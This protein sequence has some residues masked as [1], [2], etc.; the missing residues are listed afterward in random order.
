MCVA[1]FFPGHGGTIPYSMPLYEMVTKSF[2]SIHFV[3]NFIV[4]LLIATEAMLLNYII[5]ENE[6]LSKP[7]FLPAL[8][9]IVFMTTDNSLL[10][11]YPLLFANFF[12]LLAIHRLMSSYRKDTA[13]PNSF[14]ASFLLS[15]ATLFYFPCV[16]FLPILFIGFVLFRP[17]NWREWIIS[18]IGI[19]L[20]YIFIFTY[21][22][23]SDMLDLWSYKAF[24]A[25]LHE[26][27]L[28]ISSQNFYYVLSAV[29]VVVL[30]SLGKLFGGAEISQ[31]SKKSMLLLIWFSLFGVVSILMISPISIRSFSVFA[32]PF[33]VF[34]ANYFLKIKK[35]WWGELLFLLLLAVVFINRI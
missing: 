20:P 35:G 2:G 28:L 9:Y 14:D 21:Y 32:I 15:I 30:F 10:M 11:I 3:A 19:V 22:F 24:L 6:I 13:F 1:G 17:F 18:I 4:F 27:S 23:W 34:C 33:S 16:V 26:Q 7:S 25:H 8:L 29:W 31:K 12:I 5:N